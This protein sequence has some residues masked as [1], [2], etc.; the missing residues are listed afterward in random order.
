M[1]N[2]SSHQPALTDRCEHL[3]LKDD[4]RTCLAFPSNWNYCHHAR[5]VGPVKL[6][7]QRQY[8]HTPNHIQ[9]S[10]FQNEKMSPLP[11]DLRG[12]REQK[13]SRAKRF[14]GFLAWL[15]VLAFALIIFLLAQTP[16]LLIDI[17]SRVFGKTSGNVL[18]FETLP[19]PSFVISTPLVKI[20]PGVDIPTAGVTSTSTVVLV[21][22]DYPLGVPASPTFN[23][24]PTSLCGHPLDVP[25]GSKHVFIIHQAGGGES[26]NMYAINY[27]TSVAA[28]LAVNYQ[29]PVPLRNQ[30]ILVIPIG[31][32]K[33][34]ALP[35]FEPRQ[36]DATANSVETLAARFSTNLLELEQYNDFNE[37]CHTFYGWLLIPHQNPTP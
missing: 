21:P 16:S 23:L 6:E 1:K 33:L 24:W 3:G 30:S 18:P 28:I 22:S 34:D 17:N 25:F 29:L 27:K 5:P 19:A 4:S 35:S 7:H 15:F 11:P 8:C 10:V 32:T 20:P 36:A 31:E 26:L 2:N 13:K 14:P 9:C 37:S 12:S